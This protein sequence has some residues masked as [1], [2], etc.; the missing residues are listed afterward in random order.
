MRHRGGLDPRV[1]AELAKD[2]RDVDARGLAADEQRVRDLLVAP[3]A[4]DELEDLGLARG[5]PERGP[6]IR[7]DRCR[8]GPWR[9]AKVEAPEARQAF[10]LLAQRYRTEP[11]CDLERGPSGGLG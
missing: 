11:D 9:S 6:G 10:E 4:G 2:V 8:R 7:G 5:E 1:D 3:A